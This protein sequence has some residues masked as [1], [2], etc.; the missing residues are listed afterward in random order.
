MRPTLLLALLAVAAAG[1]VPSNRPAN[2]DER[3]ITIEVTLTA[4]DLT[5]DDP[6]ACRDQAVTLVVHAE[7][8]GVMHVHG[9]DEALPATEVTAGETVRVEFVA[10]RAGQFPIEF[11]AADDPEG[12]GVG[13]LTVH[14]P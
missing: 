3:E 14:E 5:P 13:V 2:C 11:H 8:D 10:E 4:T 7:A 6:A 12:T 9:Y 1:C